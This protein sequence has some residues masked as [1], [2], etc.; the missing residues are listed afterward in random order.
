MSASQVDAAV[1]SIAG[2]IAKRTPSMSFPLA[3][4][5]IH[6]AGVPL[7]IKIRAELEKLG[8]ES[9]FGQLDI[10]LYRDDAG[11]GTGVPVVHGTDIAFE[12]D[13]ARIVLVDDVLFSG[14]T[15]RAAM[16]QLMDFG[17]PALVELAVLIDRGH[18]QL[19][20]QPDYC[21]MRVETSPTDH[22]KARIDLEG[23]GSSVFLAKR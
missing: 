3:I 23:A 20:I 22:I 17:R 7:A 2:A 12:V 10:A 18:R 6:T 1:S 9:S 5:G 19:P 16:D 13:G 15:I 11:L 8:L 4:V 14:R 21:G